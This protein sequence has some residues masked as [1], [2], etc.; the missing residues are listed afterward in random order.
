[1][2]K[3]G[4]SIDGI[5]LLEKIYKG[6]ISE[7]TVILHYLENIREIV[8]IYYYNGNLFSSYEY[9]LFENHE[10]NDILNGKFFIFIEE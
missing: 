2:L 4:I 5:E 6:E 3:F 8:R 9:N 7:D 10:L 1:M